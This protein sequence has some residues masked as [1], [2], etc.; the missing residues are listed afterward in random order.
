MRVST[1]HYPDPK[2]LE[3]L[4][5]TNARHANQNSSGVAMTTSTRYFPMQSDGYAASSKGSRLR[6]SL[7][8][9]GEPLST[10][11]ARRVS[12]SKSIVPEA[13][14]QF[15]HGHSTGTPSDHSHEGKS[16]R[17]KHT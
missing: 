10:S 2:E 9:A 12:K 1:V 13:P 14:S 16:K 7:S 15:S 6:S 5:S 8:E 17:R 11:K 3:K 4:N